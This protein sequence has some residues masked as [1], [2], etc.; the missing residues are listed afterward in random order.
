MR[1]SNVLLLLVL[2][3]F[4]SCAVGQSAA[5][6]TVE[7]AES[8]PSTESVAAADIPTHSAD[9]FSDS[10]RASMSSE[11]HEFQ[12]EVTRLMDIIINSLYSNREIFIREVI[13]NAADALDKI[14][15]LALTN[16]TTLGEGEQSKLEIKISYDKEAKTLTIKDSGKISNS[17][18]QTLLYWLIS[19][20]QLT[21]F[22]WFL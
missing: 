19:E 4:L 13:S 2:F 7:S 15:Y 16:Q 5:D 1:F 6:A 14:R 17:A 8:A 22:L 11:K 20:V 18:I 10:E 21:Y 9:V 3:F 12:A